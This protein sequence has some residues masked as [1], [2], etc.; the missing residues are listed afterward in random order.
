[1]RIRL[2]K[3]LFVLSLLLNFLHISIHIAAAQAGQAELTGE[4]RDQSGAV[5][6]DTKITVTE[7]NSNQS[8]RATVGASGVYTFT[9]LKPGLYTVAAEVT[10]FKRYVR[11]GVQLATGE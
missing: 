8:Y 7:I 11:E 5:V 6:P 2:F 3:Y 10:G 4:V 1:M 9:G